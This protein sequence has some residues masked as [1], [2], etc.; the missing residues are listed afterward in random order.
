MVPELTNITYIFPIFFFFLYTLEHGEVLHS[1]SQKAALGY[2][3]VEEKPTNRCSRREK[4]LERIHALETCTQ[5]KV[6]KKMFEM[7]P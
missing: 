3:N 6:K 5:N 2:Y 1:Q 4:T 7:T